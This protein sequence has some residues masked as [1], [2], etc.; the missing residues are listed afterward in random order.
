MAL[1]LIISGSLFYA[2]ADGFKDLF[3][4]HELLDDPEEVLIVVKDAEVNDVSG[5]LAL[6]KV[7]DRFRDLD[8]HVAIS[9]LSSRSKWLMEKSAYMWQ[10]VN[11]VEVERTE[12]FEDFSLSEDDQVQDDSKCAAIPSSLTCA[13]IRGANV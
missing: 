11:F 3:E 6:K 4:L 9:Q 13:T 2:T 5:M 1:Y 10:G 8:R 12:L 7:Y